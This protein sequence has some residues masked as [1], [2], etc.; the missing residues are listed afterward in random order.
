MLVS[1]SGG[2][3]IWDS[4]IRKLAKIKA[5]N[6][7]SGEFYQATAELYFLARIKLEPKEQENL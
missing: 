6:K 1:Y 2:N 3:Y 4:L 7:V 5:V